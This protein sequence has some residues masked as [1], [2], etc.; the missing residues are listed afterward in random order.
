MIYMMMNG[1]Y[2]ELALEKIE[3][4]ND[5]SQCLDREKIYLTNYEF[6]SLFIIDNHNCDKKVMEKIQ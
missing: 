3:N 1:D 4:I 6:C 2:F 5:L